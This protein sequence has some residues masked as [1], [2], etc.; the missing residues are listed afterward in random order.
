M[1]TYGK[2]VLVDVEGGERYAIELPMPTSGRLRKLGVTQTAG[3]D[4]GFTLA[5]YDRRGAC[6]TG[7]DR[8]VVG[9]AVSELENAGGSVKLTTVDDHGLAVG[10]EI[11]LKETGIG[12]YEGGPHVVTTVVN[13]TTVVLGLAY[14]ADA[15]TGY[16]QTPPEVFPTAVNTVVHRVL[17]EQEVAAPGETYSDDT[18]DLPF[19]NRDNQSLTARRKHCALYLD[20][21]VEGSGE[22]SFEIDYIVSDAPE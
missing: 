4:D 13:S 3:S 2:S 11:E 14:T 5:V 1:R 6:P 9:G 20:L 18:L 15:S 19:V 22:K 12:G 17:D 7:I 16:W 21:D 8:H 10:D